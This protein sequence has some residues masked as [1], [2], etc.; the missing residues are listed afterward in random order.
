MKGKISVTE[1]DIQK[2]YEALGL[3]IE[4]TEDV[5][6]GGDG[7]TNGGKDQTLNKA[8]AMK[9]T[10]STTSTSAWRTRSR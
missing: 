7:C 6:K 10:R 3:D 5:Q 1:E 2:A 8:K 4:P 9:A